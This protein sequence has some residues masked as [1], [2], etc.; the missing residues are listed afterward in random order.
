LGAS[1]LKKQRNVC[2]ANYK[3]GPREMYIEEERT[4]TV[5]LLHWGT[6]FT[7]V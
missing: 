5:C 3:E 6:H 4:W 2:V 1:G 7:L